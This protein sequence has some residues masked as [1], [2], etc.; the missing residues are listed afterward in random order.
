MMRREAKSTDVEQE[1]R[2]A[3]RVFDKD[4]SGTISSDELYQVMLS[5]GEQLSNEEL[6]AMIHEVDKN[7]DGSIDCQCTELSIQ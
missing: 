6:E 5:F 3:F 1:L 2:D 7:N 4:N